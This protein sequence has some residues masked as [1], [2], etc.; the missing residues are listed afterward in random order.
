MYYFKVRRSVLQ[1]NVSL[2]NKIQF[3][4]EEA[5]PLPAPWP[6][7]QHFLPYLSSSAQGERSTAPWLQLKNIITKGKIKGGGG[8]ARIFKSLKKI[9]K[10]KL[11]LG[12]S[13]D[14]VSSNMVLAWIGELECFHLAVH[15]AL[16]W[17]RPQEVSLLSGH[18]QPRGPGIT[19]HPTTSITRP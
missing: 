17:D 3:C 7:V 12:I 2:W 9:C 4:Q 14:R 5:F 19:E 1:R 8:G 11:N 6:V 15:T 18:Q 13:E 16:L 10:R